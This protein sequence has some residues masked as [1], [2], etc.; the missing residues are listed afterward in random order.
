MTN[1][2]LH[3]DQLYATPLHELP[4]FVFDEAVAGVFSDM[5]SRSVPGYA[6]IIRMIGLLASRQQQSGRYYDLGCSLGAASL[7]MSQGV[8]HPES[9]II[10]ID[11]SL[12][13]LNKARD[14]L[15]QHDLSTPVQLV[16]AD[17]MD[18]QIQQALMVVLNFTLQFI[19]VDQRE[20]LLRKVYEN[21][22]PD[23]ALILS[24]KISFP[25]E[26]F[27][28]LFVDMHHQFKR[29]QGYSELEISQKRSAL[30]RVLIPET[31][32][33]HLNRLK[34]I[35]FNKVSVWFQCFNF[36]SLIAVK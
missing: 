14:H 28:T 16:C 11:N 12:P 34:S 6:T 4:D 36:V 25:D 20:A 18:V 32:D 22:L 19:S 1:N 2:N 3:K 31:L 27:E 8:H 13:M 15:Q 30:E 23:G 9:E 17:V 10:A 33:S 26:E 5:I 29:D 7:A 24:E 35:G 21:L